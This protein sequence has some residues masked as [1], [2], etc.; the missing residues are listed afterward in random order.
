MQRAAIE[1]QSAIQHSGAA[2]RTSHHI[3]GVPDAQGKT[4]IQLQSG[5]LRHRHIT[6]DVQP[7]GIEFE[8]AIQSSHIIHHHCR[9]IEKLGTRAGHLDAHAI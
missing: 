1:H 8:R 6:L 9:A 7:R 3:Q 4:I 2:I 5:T